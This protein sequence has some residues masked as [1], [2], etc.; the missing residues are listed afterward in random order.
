MVTPLLVQ[1]ASSDHA[2]IYSSI[3]IGL[4]TFLLPVSTIRL[5]KNHISRNK[6]GAALTAWV[7]TTEKGNESYFQFSSVRNATQVSQDKNI[8]EQALSFD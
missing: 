8:N 3:E 6:E 5:K 1:K 2:K 7:L 4:H